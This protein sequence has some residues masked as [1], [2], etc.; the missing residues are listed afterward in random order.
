[1]LP[2]RDNLNLVDSAIAASTEPNSTG[3]GGSINIDPQVVT[4]NNS[5]IAVNSQGEGTG[6]SII[7]QAD[8]LNLDNQS[9]ISAET[10]ST[11]GGN[12]EIALN[13]NLILRDNSQISATAGT[14]R[15]GGDVGETHLNG[16]DKL[17]VMC[18]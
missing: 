7:M 4:L 17:S 11:D 10:L 6:G 8:N 2:I 16:I 12:I 13:E 18:I 9:A 15:L 3:Q 1:M 5:Q 14:A